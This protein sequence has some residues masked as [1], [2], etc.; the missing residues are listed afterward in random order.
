MR[1]RPP[2]AIVELR[3]DLPMHMDKHMGKHFKIRCWSKGR[4]WSNAGLLCSRPCGHCCS[5]GH[6]WTSWCHGDVRLLCNR[7][8]HICFCYCA[9]N[10]IWKSWLMRRMGHNNLSRNILHRVKRVEP[11][12]LKLATLLRAMGQAIAL[13]GQVYV[14]LGRWADDRK[15][16]DKSYCQL[17]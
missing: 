5:M 17:G 13:P 3:M 6:W 1:H 4:C 10:V 8:C 16:W 7:P 14:S 9:G 2:H 15:T 12:G 11:L